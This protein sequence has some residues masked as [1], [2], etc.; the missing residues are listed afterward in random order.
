MQDSSR[1]KA[2][3]DPVVLK[4]AA[5]LQLP[6]TWQMS[7]LHAVTFGGFVAFATY[8]PTYLKDVYS[9]NLTEAGTRTAGFA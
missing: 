5:A 1:R 9:F 8:L 7:F 4:L 6:V 3:H 2:N